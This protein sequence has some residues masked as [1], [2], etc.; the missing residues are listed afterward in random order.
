MSKL[1][2]SALD[3]VTGGFKKD[4]LSPDE[5]KTWH[6]LIANVEDL[7]KKQAAGM[8]TEAQVKRAD[9]KLLSFI[10]GMMTKYDM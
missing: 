5:I 10:R 4:R 3:Q 7:E 6:E 2:D 8:A 1:T 9:D